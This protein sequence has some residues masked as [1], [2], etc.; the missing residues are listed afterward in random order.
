MK[1]LKIHELMELSCSKNIHTND[2]SVEIPLEN[3]V[4]IENTYFL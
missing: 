3:G 4:A 1:T 2:F